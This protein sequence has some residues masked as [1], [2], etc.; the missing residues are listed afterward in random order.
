M[1]AEAR[2][3]ALPDPRALRQGGSLQSRQAWAARARSLEYVGRTGIQ[4]CSPVGPGGHTGCL[5]QLIATA[6]AEANEDESGSTP[7]AE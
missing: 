1:R 2:S 7:P 3:R 6:R 4:S 5:E